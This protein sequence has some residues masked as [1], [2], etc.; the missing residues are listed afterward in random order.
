MQKNMNRE[1]EWRN[2]T[3]VTGNNVA[4]CEKATSVN[5]AGS[6][7]QDTSVANV[8]LWTS[9]NACKE[10]CHKSSTNLQMEPK[11]ITALDLIYSLIFIKWL[12]SSIEFCRFI[13]EW[14]LDAHILHQRIVD[15]FR[16]KEANSHKSDM[17]QNPVIS[18][19]FCI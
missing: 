1:K 18:G 10:S 13:W 17:L 14:K 19:L 16:P 2:V 12:N 3:L 11:D 5:E 6:G 7:L 8:R 15:L 9:L 4:A